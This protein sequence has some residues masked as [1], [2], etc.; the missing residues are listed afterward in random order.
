MYI[1]VCS[2]ALLFTIVQS[3][4]LVNNDANSNFFSVAMP[5]AHVAFQRY[6]N[7]AGGQKVI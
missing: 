4:V 5:H 6:F 3:Q 7:G 2:V 1:K